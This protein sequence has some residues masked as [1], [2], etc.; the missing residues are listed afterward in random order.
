MNEDLEQR[1]A[2]LE[3]RAEGDPSGPGWIETCDRISAR[4]A[5]RHEA[6]KPP[7]LPKCLFAVGDRV[8]WDWEN[9]GTVRTG[10]V[11]KVRLSETITGS[12]Y[13]LWVEGADHTT[14]ALRAADCHLDRRVGERRKR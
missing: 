2:D 7:E 14:W 8:W 10:T 3:E 4:N 1:V 5:V 11:A 13:C 9:S 6:E 12:R